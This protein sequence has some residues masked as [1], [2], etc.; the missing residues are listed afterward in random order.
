MPLSAKVRIELFIHDLPD[1][2]YFN[3]LERLGDELSYAFGGCTVIPASGKY[4]SE[5]G[6]MKLRS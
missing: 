1:P 6:L 3:L 2:I 5:S 4:R